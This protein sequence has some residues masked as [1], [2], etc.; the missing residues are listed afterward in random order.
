M[1]TTIGSFART[2]TG[3]KPRTLYSNCPRHMILEYTSRERTMKNHSDNISHDKADF[4]QEHYSQS[5]VILTPVS[6]SEG[7]LSRYFSNL[8]SLTY[9]H[10]L[11]SVVIGE[12]SSTDNTYQQVLANINTIRNAFRRTDV[13]K[14]PDS[15]SIR[16]SRTR[17]DMGF[18]IYRR[19]QL[20][21]SRNRLLFSGLKDEVWVL[22]IDSD[23]KYL[24][25][26]IIEQ[27]LSAKK[28]VVAPACMYMK[29]SSAEADVYD[30]NTW[31]DTER[32]KQ[33]LKGKG[34]HFL[35]VEGYAPPMRLYMDKLRGKGS[36]VDLDGVGGCV[37]LV[38]ANY[39]RS[40]LNF[41]PF[42]FNNHIETEGLAKMAQRMEYKL[43]GMPFVE[44]FHA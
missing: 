17:H 43:Y 26:D 4:D 30:K 20:A 11:I 37:L 38:K 12:D 5:V 25:P 31:Q 18:Q 9:P 42:I 21:L 7:H 34:E 13:L 1:N 44:V 14:L 32:S 41:P 24:P 15:L 16:P 10:E 35:M 36:L 19:K 8:C 27:L 23:V 2:V 40:G 33:F 29:G 22:W 28:E 3:A 39:H 6:N